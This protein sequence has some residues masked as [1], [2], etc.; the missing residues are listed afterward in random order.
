MCQPES[1]VKPTRRQIFIYPPVYFLFWQPSGRLG[2]AV[3]AVLAG[4]LRFTLLGLPLF[5][6]PILFPLPLLFSG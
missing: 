6:S 1:P 2:T 4:L 3:H 5:S